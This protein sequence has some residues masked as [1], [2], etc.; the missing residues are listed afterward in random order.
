MSC[1]ICHR[2]SCT[3][4][5]HSLEA[6]E[7][8]EARK[9]MSDDVDILRVQLQEAHEEIKALNVELEDLEAQRN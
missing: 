5:F 1:P 8:Y 3:L 4:S 2:S 9:G 7:K 6:Q